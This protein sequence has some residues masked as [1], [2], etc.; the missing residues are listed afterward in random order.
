[1]AALLAR[2]PEAE[3]VSRIG[4]GPRPNVERAEREGHEPISRMRD[5][6]RCQKCGWTW[7]KI[8]AYGYPRCYGSRRKRGLR[9]AV[10]SRGN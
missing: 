1:V 10:V 2:T 9:P 6:K 5:G 3:A 8:A 7:E 4:W